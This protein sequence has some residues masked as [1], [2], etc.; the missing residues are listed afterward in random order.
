[1]CLVKIPISFQIKDINL[2]LA[3][4]AI[5]REIKQIDYSSSLISLHVKLASCCAFSGFCSPF[6][7]SSFGPADQRLGH[8]AV[9]RCIPLRL[10]SQI[11]D[12]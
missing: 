1:V 7:P 2:F 8:S 4:I 10:S 3:K 11:L 12:L 5:R 6:L 9:A